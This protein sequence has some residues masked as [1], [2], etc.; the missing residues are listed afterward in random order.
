VFE[1]PKFREGNR[2]SGTATISDFYFDQSLSPRGSRARFDVG[3]RW[4]RDNRIDQTPVL[5]RASFAYRLGASSKLEL[6]W[7]Q[8]AQFP[9]IYEVFAPIHNPGLLPQRATHYVAAVEH[10]FDRE[11]R[12]RLEA[13][14][15]DYRDVLDTPFLFPRLVN[16][17]ISWPSLPP[18]YFNSV[19]GYTRG[20]EIVL[21][22]RSANRLNGWIS[23]DL[24]YSRDRDSL[25]HTSYAAEN[26]RRHAVNLYGSYRVTPSVNLSARWT[27]GSG[28]PIPGYW[29]YVGGGNYSVS[30]VQ[31]AERLSAYERLDLRLN[32]SVIHEK[33]KMTWYAEVVNA[34]NHSNERFMGIGGDFALNAYPRYGYT[35]N[36][37]PSV[38]VS[39]DF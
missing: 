18:Q 26:D 38:G 7:G 23:Y 6:G 19:R 1:D 37:L 21:Q 28:T 27:Y 34:L 13:Y 20:I 14:D 9:E 25:T 8:Y 39:V 3:F 36:L 24:G 32:K 5:P 30:A 15:R 4:S 31:N 33:W 2:Y 22:R 35:L 12:L 16:G 17:I 10:R 11:T 29:T